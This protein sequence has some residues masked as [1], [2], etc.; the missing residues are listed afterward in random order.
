MLTTF[1]SEL[2]VPIYK[3]PRP[4]LEDFGSKTAK[5]IESDEF[6][7]L[8]A[9]GYTVV[10]FDFGIMIWLNASPIATVTNKSQR[11]NLKN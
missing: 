1:A 7:N 2:I 5:Y 3:S 9:N 8:P 4:L 11:L 10:W 6:K